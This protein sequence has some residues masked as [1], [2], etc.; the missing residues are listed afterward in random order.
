MPARHRVFLALPYHGAVA[1][2]SVRGAFRFASRKHDLRISERDVSLLAFSFNMLLAECLTKRKAEGLTHFAMLHADVEPEHWWIDLLAD[3]MEKHGA[4]VVS[5]V[6][7]LK[8]NTGVTSTA[9]EEPGNAFTAHCRLT[10]KRVHA[11]PETFGIA[12]CGFTD[13]R[14]L[15]VNSGCWLMR[16]GDWSER[17]CFTVRDRMTK[18]DDGTFVAEV[19]PEDWAMSRF[20]RDQ[21]LK[22]MATRKVGVI[23]HGHAEFPNWPGWG[24]DAD[25]DA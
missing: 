11:L 18:R 15:L 4:D 17:M 6:V 12:D 22:V 7:P 13:G 8:A 9:V 24:K 5:A 21:G 20:W 10:L 16:L 14:A 25:P 19:E 1:P 23:H 2:G 3:E